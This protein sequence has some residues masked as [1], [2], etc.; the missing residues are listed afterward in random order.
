[1]NTRP[2]GKKRLASEADQEAGPSNPNIGTFIN[3]KGDHV[4]QL[5]PAAPLSALASQFSEF[6]GWMERVSKEHDAKLED[7]TAAR[8][9]AN[10]ALATERAAREE[11]ELERDQAREALSQADRTITTQSAELSTLKAAL[12]AKAS[13]LTE[14]AK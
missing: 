2:H 1:M 14:L 4:F 6:A 8:L 12:K 10:E 11:A 3:M 13:E 7:E 9:E 5:S